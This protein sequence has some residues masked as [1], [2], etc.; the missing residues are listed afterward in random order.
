MWIPHISVNFCKIRYHAVIF[1]CSIRWWHV[2]SSELELP[3]IVNFNNCVF[4]IHFCEY[5]CNFM[6]NIRRVHPML[7][8]NWCKDSLLPNKRTRCGLMNECYKWKTLTT[9]FICGFG[10]GVRRKLIYNALPPDFCIEF[11]WALLLTFLTVSKCI[12][13]PWFPTTFIQNTF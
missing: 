13:T 1:A 7:Q 8:V 10:F 12:T 2:Y 11:Y 3:F 5:Y 4:H 9:K 6:I